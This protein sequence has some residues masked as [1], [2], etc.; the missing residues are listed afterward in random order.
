MKHC[1]L[2]SDLGEQPHSILLVS[3]DSSN[4]WW[5]WTPRQ[6]QLENCN[7]SSGSLASRLPGNVY[8]DI[9]QYSFIVEIFKLQGIIWPGI[10]ILQK[11]AD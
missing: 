6:L 8:A 11:F 4:L 7:L 10:A 2:L 9:H 5:H 3:R 1:K